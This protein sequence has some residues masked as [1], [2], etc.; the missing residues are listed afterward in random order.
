[1]SE[2]GMVRID[3]KPLE[4]GLAV[5]KH[6]AETI[7]VK[8]APTCLAAKTAQ[9][10]VRNY[11]KDVHLKLDPFVESAKR[12]LQSAKDEL[13]KWLVP[14][15]AID[16]ALA[17]KVKDYERRERE[18][19]EAE[20]R[21]QNEERRIVAEKQAAV[22]RA[23]REKSAAEERKRREAEI[24]AQKRAGEIKAREAQRLAK[25][26]REAEERERERAK[27]DEVIAAANVVEV[28]VEPN[29]PKVAGVPSR[30]NYKFR[31]IDANRIPRQYLIPNEVKI[32]ADV[33]E[34]K[35]EGEVI[36]GIEAY[37]D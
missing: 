20:T 3:T 22:E 30:T 2:T 13:N 7:V 27:S 12:N 33:R 10:D 29:I 28:K 9:R 32:G 26:A 8:D 19:A 23:E 21:R 34:W 14:A 35:K 36:P 24:E 4:A 16:E 6:T 25:E 18:A 37:R 11:L 1:M 31:I 5:L 15:T 17:V